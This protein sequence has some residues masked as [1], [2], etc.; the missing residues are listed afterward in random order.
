MKIVKNCLLTVSA[1]AWDF[2]DHRPDTF[3]ESLPA[4]L[5]EDGAHCVETAALL[6]GLF[7]LWRLITFWT[8]AVITLVSNYLICPFV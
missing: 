5:L 4:R 3:R 1:L 2:Q 7:G 6:A 8:R